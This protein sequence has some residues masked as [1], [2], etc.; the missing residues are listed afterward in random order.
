MLH[1]W[2]WNDGCQGARRSELNGCPLMMCYWKNMWQMF[3][4]N[5]W[6]L[7]TMTCWPPKRFWIGGHGCY[8]WSNGAT[9]HY[10]IQ[11]WGRLYSR[12]FQ[13][14]GHFKPT[15]AGWY[16]SHLER[17]WPQH[18]TQQEMKI[19][20]DLESHC[21]VWEHRSVKTP[22]HG[23]PSWH[24]CCQRT[25]TTRDLFAQESVPECCHFIQFHPKRWFHK[26]V[27]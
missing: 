1:R 4:N 3:V 22:R 19:Q 24:L 18:G 25:P 16:S 9:D 21:V 7:L 13:S 6:K 15:V 27:C 10:F 14:H 23:V 11:G 17:S 26:V 5:D 2:V 12:Q 20:F 8:P